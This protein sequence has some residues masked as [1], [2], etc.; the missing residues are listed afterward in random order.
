V[1]PG[2]AFLDVISPCVA[3]NNHAGSTKSYEYVRDH[4]EA[5]NTIDFDYW[6]K[7][8]EISVEYPEGEVVTVTQHDGSMLRLRKLAADYDPH[9]RIRAMNFV[10]EHHAR[11]E[12]ATGLL[13]VHPHPED[14]HQ[15]LNTFGA[16]FNALGAKELCPGSAALDKLNA[17]LR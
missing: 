15:H 17:S 9:D 4:N 16:P 2:A 14:L 3:F 5:V 6:P 11:G 13:Y 1:H 10:Q 12:V 7:R 8:E